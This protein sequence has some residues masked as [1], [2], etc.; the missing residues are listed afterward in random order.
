MLASA[1]V[2]AAGEPGTGRMPRNAAILALAGSISFCALFFGGGFDDAA[3]V[4]IGG[5]ALVL[6]AALAGSVLAGLLPGLG[7]ERPSA[8]FLSGLFGLAIFAG[9]STLWSLSPDRS[10]TYANRTLVYAAFGLVGLSLAR[11][12]RRTTVAAGAALLIGLVLGWALL[13]KCV[14]ALYTDYGRIAR[15]RAPVGYWN[16]LALLC[17][18]AVPLG[19]WL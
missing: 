2:H 18:V 8:V 13:A 16:E 4:W 9:V 1:P 17:D 3:L 14:P 10:W 7:L 12:A 6:A 5:S 19:L 15:L 11:F